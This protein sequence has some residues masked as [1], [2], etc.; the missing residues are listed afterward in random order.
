MKTRTRIL[1][2]SSFFLMFLFGYI[3]YLIYLPPQNV[4]NYYSVS[5]NNLIKHSEDYEGF[6]II[7]NGNINNISISEKTAI[8]HTD[9]G[10][11]VFNCSNIDISSLSTGDFVYFKGTSFL[12]TKGYIQVSE[13]RIQVSYSLELSLIGLVIALLLLFVVLKFDWKS[14]SFQIRKN[15]ED[16]DDA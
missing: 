7:I 11:L 9:I 3:N 6:N 15:K 2:F 13:V 4:N 5:I 1:L 12:I 8:F 10:D 14:F 16:I